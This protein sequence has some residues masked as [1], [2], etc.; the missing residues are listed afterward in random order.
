MR[1]PVARLLAILLCLVPGGAGAQV[2]LRGAPVPPH[3]YTPPPPRPAAPP[4]VPSRLPL[5]HPAPH[6]TLHGSV[7]LFRAGPH[8][9]R[10]HRDPRVRAYGPYPYVP[11]AGPI[12]WPPQ[13]DWRQEALVPVIVIQQPVQAPSAAPPAAGAPVAPPPPSAAAPARP[14]RFYVIPGCYAGSTPPRAARLPKGCDPSRVRPLD[15]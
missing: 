8:T 15:R 12:Y 4:P 2:Q 9:Y 5:P 11:F 3:R 7:D 10:P 14:Q 6:V 1:G 13:D